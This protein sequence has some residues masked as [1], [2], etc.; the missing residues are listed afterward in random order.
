MTVFEISV[1]VGFVITIVC[2]QRC[3]WRFQKRSWRA[4]VA[5]RRVPA[6]L[7]T[8]PMFK[9]KWARWCSSHETF[10]DSFTPKNIHAVS[11]KWIMMFSKFQSDVVR[12]KISPGKKI[13]NDFI[14]D[15]ERLALLLGN[16]L[17]DRNWV[18]CG[19]DS[20]ISSMFRMPSAHAIHIYDL[21]GTIY[22]Q[23]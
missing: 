6:K 3:M 7:W 22:G 23:T 19:G 16:K 15:L 4:V 5:A 21:A 9:C 2:R 1:F 20:H 10:T 12:I 17:A 11:V 13:E 18:T 14:W 8:F